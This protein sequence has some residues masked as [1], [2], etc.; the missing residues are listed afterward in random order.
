MTSGW[1]TSDDR[2]M[3]A[4]FGCS[5]FLEV[6]SS[7]RSSS[8][9]FSSKS[10][11]DL[12]RVR[13]L[14]GFGRRRRGSSVFRSREKKM[15]MYHFCG[16]RRWKMQR[17]FVLRIRT[18]KQLLFASKN[19][20]LSSKESSIFGSIFSP[21]FSTDNRRRRWF[22]LSGPKIKMGN[23]ISFVFRNRSSKRQGSSGAEEED[24]FTFEEDLPSSKKLYIPSSFVGSSDLSSRSKIEDERIFVFVWS[25]I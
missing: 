9:R 3:T 11:E 5:W 1:R 7:D 21:T 2:L 8:S 23:I 12:T 14:R 4:F 18:N 13:R 25:N 10:S 17:L 6:R 24:L 16:S 15:E 22:R 20:L 19:T